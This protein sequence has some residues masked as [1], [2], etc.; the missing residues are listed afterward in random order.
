MLDG[1]RDVS[2]NFWELNPHQVVLL[3]LDVVDFVVR[4]TIQRSVP[5]PRALE[6]TILELL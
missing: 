1:F 2:R 3:L 6:S 4:V 5:M